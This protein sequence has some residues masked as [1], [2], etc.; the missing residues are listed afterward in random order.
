MCLL[1]V[2]F[3]AIGN[4]IIPEIITYKMLKKKFSLGANLDKIERFVLEV[5]LRPIAINMPTSW[6]VQRNVKYYFLM[7]YSYFGSY[8]IKEVSKIKF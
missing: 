6:A 5:S 8:K 4:F 3:Q 1:K 7:S 2:V